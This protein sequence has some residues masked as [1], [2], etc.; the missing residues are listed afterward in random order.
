MTKLKIKYL[1]TEDISEVTPERWER[2]KNG[3]F[4]D[5]FQLIEAPVVPKEV[6]ESLKPKTNIA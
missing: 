4:K 5:D 2:I 3:D 1:P 6:S